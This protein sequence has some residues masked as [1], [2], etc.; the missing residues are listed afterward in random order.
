MLST[1]TQL[2]PPAT[3]VPPWMTCPY[4]S[5]NS[6]GRLRSLLES[7]FFPSSGNWHGVYTWVGRCQPHKHTRSHPASTYCA[8]V[9]DSHCVALLWEVSTVAVRSNME[10]TVTPRR[11]HA[12]N[13]APRRAHSP[14][15]S[16]LYGNTHG[17]VLHTRAKKCASSALVPQ[18][19]AEI[20]SAHTRICASQLFGQLV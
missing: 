18:V 2:L 6:K 1:P 8:N 14:S 20:S 10:A 12:R 7:N 9:V 15:P 19:A 5:L 11:P 13:R 16:R 4:P 17:H 3:G